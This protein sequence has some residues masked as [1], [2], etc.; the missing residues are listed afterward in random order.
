MVWF[1]ASSP[2]GNIKSEA[3]WPRSVSYVTQAE[4]QTALI[5]KKKKIAKSLVKY[6]PLHLRIW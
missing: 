4:F 1:L 2:S 3:L 6:I 5:D